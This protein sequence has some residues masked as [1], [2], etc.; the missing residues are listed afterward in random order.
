MPTFWGS[1]MFVRGRSGEPRNR[2]L[3]RPTTRRPSKLPG[4]TCRVTPTTTVWRPR[5]CFALPRW[6][7]RPPRR[8]LRCCQPSRIRFIADHASGLPVLRTLS[9]C[10]CCRHYPGAAA[11]PIL[12]HSPS[13]I[14]LPRKGRR[15]GLRIVLFEAC[16]AFTR[17]AAR[18]IAQPPTGDLCH[19]A[20]TRAVAH[21]SR[22]SATG[23]IDNPP[24]GFLLH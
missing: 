24:V 10:T 12:A 23:L 8:S 3:P 2:Q 5:W 22:S 6:R 17:V 20:P 19:E 1:S 14:S 11:G 13:R 18:R 21:T 15:V 7:L 9:L 16:S 4:V